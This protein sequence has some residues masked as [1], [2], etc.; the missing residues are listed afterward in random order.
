MRNKF[1]FAQNLMR[2]FDIFLISE[3]K[4][5]LILYV[6]EQVSCKKLINYE[7]PIASETIVLEFNQSKRKWLILGI[8]KTPNQ[9][10]AAFLQH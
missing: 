4:L 1:V 8:Y 10:E 9:K 2:D 6:N 5:G 7:N 3:F